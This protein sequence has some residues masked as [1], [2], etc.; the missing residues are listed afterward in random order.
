VTSNTIY[1]GTP[2]P[3]TTAEGY[4]TVP[5]VAGSY[6]TWNRGFNLPTNITG[7]WYVIHCKIGA[8]LGQTIPLCGWEAG[9]GSLLIASDN[10]PQMY[11][12][13][14][15]TASI[16]NFRCPNPIPNLTTDQWIW[17]WAAVNITNAECRYHY[18]HGHLL[19][20][21]SYFGGGIGTF[22]GGPLIATGTNI[23]TIGA[24]GT[25]PYL[26]ITWDYFAEYLNNGGAPSIEI[27]LRKSDTLPANVSALGSA[28]LTPRVRQSFPP[29]LKD[30][31]IGTNRVWPLKVGD[32][33]TPDGVVDI[34][35]G[36]TKVW[37]KSG[38]AKWDVSQYDDGTVW[39]P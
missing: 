1:H 10:K 19:P 15:T 20:A 9:Y 26:P 29:A 39:G 16:G 25:T 37:P 24:R 7:V 36:D 21:W 38:V 3:V 28:T 27:D 6:F 2:V 8:T 31:Y 23:V 32:P 35:L 4:G 33:L 30:H 18:C 11:V 22:P 17:I 5:G 12:R 13:T 34:H 14:T